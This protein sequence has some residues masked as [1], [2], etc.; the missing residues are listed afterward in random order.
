VSDSALAMAEGVRAGWQSDW[1]NGAVTGIA[2]LAA[3]VPTSRRAGS[4]R[5][6]GPDG[7]RGGFCASVPG[8]ACLESRTL[9]IG[10][11]TQST[12]PCA[13]AIKALIS[14][15]SAAR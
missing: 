3:E 8:A 2:G 15:V 11:A 4:L 14:P 13:W 1:G 5:R 12:A 6:A 7:Q 9:S 10:E